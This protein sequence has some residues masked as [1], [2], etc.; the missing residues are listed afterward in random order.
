MADGR[1]LF[2]SYSKVINFSFVMELWGLSVRGRGGGILLCVI[3]SPGDIF[4]WGVSV[5]VCGMHHGMQDR[6]L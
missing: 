3:R 4:G 1:Y 6:R 5:G 2:I